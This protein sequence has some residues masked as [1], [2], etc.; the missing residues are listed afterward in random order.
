MKKVIKF[1]KSDLILFFLAL[2]LVAFVLF[3][4]DKLDRTKQMR[5]TSG[6]EIYIQQSDTTY[7][8]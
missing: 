5:T 2:L 7:S 3:L 6:K 1:F 8:Y 4:I